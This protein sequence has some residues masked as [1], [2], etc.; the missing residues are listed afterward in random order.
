MWTRRVATK[1]GKT[2]AKAVRPGALCGRLPFVTKRRRRSPDPGV[3]IV[4]RFLISFVL[5]ARAGAPTPR[6]GNR[7]ASIVALH[8]KEDM[9][10]VPQGLVRRNLAAIERPDP[11]GGA[12]HFSLERPLPQ[13]LCAALRCSA[14]LMSHADE[15]STC[16]RHDCQRANSVANQQL[17]SCLRPARRFIAHHSQHPTILITP[18]MVGPEGLSGP[19]RGLTLAIEIRTTIPDTINAHAT[20]RVP[21]SRRSLIA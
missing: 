5:P 4:G 1:G 2:K 17:K 19:H 16:R 3:P 7:P 15:K 11:Q 20:H 10:L 18:P 12:R 21:I 13:R 9:P 14:S 8:G 6:V